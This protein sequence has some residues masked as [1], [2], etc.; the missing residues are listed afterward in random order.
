MDLKKKKREALL[1]YALA[2]KKA[3][4]SRDKNLVRKL[5]KLEEELEKLTIKVD[6]TMDP[7]LKKEWKE[8]YQ[9]YRKI[10]LQ[11]RITSRKRPKPAVRK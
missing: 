5:T 10:A 1:V 8:A 11:R 7:A 3:N 4:D 6:K 9:R 2:W